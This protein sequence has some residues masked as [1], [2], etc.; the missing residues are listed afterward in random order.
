MWWV[1][2]I[3]G[4][5][6]VVAFN[7]YAID[8]TRARRG[9]WRIRES[10]LHLLALFGGFIGSLAGQRVFRHKYRKTGF[11]ALT[12]GIGMLHVVFW[13]WIALRTS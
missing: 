7:A 2:G 12:W 4:L 9:R 13:V 5:M 1:I 10:T 6:S 8:K 11:V 3:Y